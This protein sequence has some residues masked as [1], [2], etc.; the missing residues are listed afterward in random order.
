MFVENKKKNI[1]VIFLGNNITNSIIT[2]NINNTINN[3][4][5][6]ENKNNDNEN[7]DNKNNKVEDL[8]KNNDGIKSKTNNSNM[9]PI[10]LDNIDFKISNQISCPIYS[11]SFIPTSENTIEKCGHLFYNNCWYDFSRE[12]SA[13]RPSGT[14]LGARIYKNKRKKISIY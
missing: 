3:E 12:K 9:E 5:N 1:Y 8:N 7:E 6:D 14:N 11:D 13:R 10:Q 2:F 4:I